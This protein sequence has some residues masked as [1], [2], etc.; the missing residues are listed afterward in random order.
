MALKLGNDRLLNFKLRTF[1]K[2]VQELAGV[3]LNARCC[4]VSSS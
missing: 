4:P 2:S 1:E 3:Y